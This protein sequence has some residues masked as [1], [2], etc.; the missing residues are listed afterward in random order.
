MWLGAP[1][2]PV[3]GTAP[4]VRHDVRNSAVTATHAKVRSVWWDRR[5]SQ[6]VADDVTLQRERARAQI[7]VVP[8]PILK[9]VAAPAVA[10][11]EGLDGLIEE[12]CRVMPLADGVGLAAPQLGVSK[13]VIAVRTGDELPPLVLLNPEVIWT[14]EATEEMLEGCL[15][16]PGIQVPVVR[17]LTVRVRGELPDGSEHISKMSGMLARIIQH[18]ID[19]LDGILITDRTRPEIRRELALAR[20]GG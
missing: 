3:S 20:V 5:Y 8:D 10:G 13:R 16:I 7:H 12:L 19:H 9:S 1:M 18:E 14:G 4:S 2:V 17:H 15:S 6:G 11:E